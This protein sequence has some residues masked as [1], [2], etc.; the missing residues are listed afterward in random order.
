MIQV[1]KSSDRGHGDHGWL[2]SFH[3]FSFANYHDPQHMGFRAL[4]VMNEDR[5]AGGQGFGTHAHQ[6]MEIVSYVLDGALEHK[7]SMGNGEI[8]KPGEFQ[9]ISAGSGI[10]HSEFN[11]SPDHSTHFYQIW[12]LPESKGISPSYEQKS[13]DPALRQNRLQLVASPDA[14][15]DSLTIHQDVRIF[16]AD[17]AANKKIE[18]QLLSLRHAWIQVLR[19]EVAINGQSLQTGDG[20]ALSDEHKLQILGQSDSEIMLFDL[21]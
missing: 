9:R 19:G 16:L 3:T 6:D 17:I 14:A 12:L 18:H 10:T 2:N 7:D 13:F 15:E 1:R 21:A 4:R 20:I 5:I 8:L 11:P